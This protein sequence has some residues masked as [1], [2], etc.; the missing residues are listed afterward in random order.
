MV[1]LV[2]LQDS[3]GSG[4]FGEGFL[5]V[6]NPASSYTQF[7]INIDYVD[8]GP[9][10]KAFIFIGLGSEFGG[11]VGSWFQVDNLELS[12]VSAIGDDENSLPD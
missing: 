11:N 7:T 8:P 4:G 3:T 12:G 5:Q 9:V 2:A 1:I 6:T 10:N